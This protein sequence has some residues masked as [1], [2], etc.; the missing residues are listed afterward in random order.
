MHTEFENAYFEW[1]LFELLKSKERNRVLKSINN[2]GEEVI[3]S[4]GSLNWCLFQS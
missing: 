1:N 4:F 2:Y 3:G